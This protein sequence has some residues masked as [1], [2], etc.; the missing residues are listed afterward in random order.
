MPWS[1]I[2]KIFNTFESKRVSFMGLISSF[3]SIACF[4]AISNLPIEYYTFLRFIVSIGAVLNIYRWITKKNLLLAAA[5]TIILTLFNPLVPFY[6]HVKNIWIPFDIISGLLFLLNNFKKKR[7]PESISENREVLTTTKSYSRDRI[8]T[9]KNEPT[10][11][12]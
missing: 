7:L 4:L 9:A 3:C 8:I 10:V 11:N 5:F 2:K 1:A 6:L 12:N